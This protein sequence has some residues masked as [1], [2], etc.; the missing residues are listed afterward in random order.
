MQYSTVHAFRIP[1]TKTLSFRISKSRTPFSD[2]ASCMLLSS[3]LQDIVTTIAD[4]T[5][6]TIWIG[7]TAF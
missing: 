7:P 6:K 1:S 3:L 4:V 5:V 2:P